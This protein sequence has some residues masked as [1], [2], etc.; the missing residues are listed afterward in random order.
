MGWKLRGAALR[1]IRQM[2]AGYMSKKRAERGRW[3]RRQGVA[4]K[5][6]GGGETSCQQARS[7]HFHISLDACDLARE[8]QTRIGFQPQALIK[9]LRAVQERVA[10]QAAQPRKR[11]TFEAGD[12]A[13]DARLLA[14]LELGL[15]SDH[16]P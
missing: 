8:T 15:K 5:K 16:V 13:E 11:S 3:R 10:M 1:R 4:S 7:R 14:M 6:L 2:A 9:Q 12:H